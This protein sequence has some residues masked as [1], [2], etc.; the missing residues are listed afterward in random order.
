MD[1]QQLLAQY[2]KTGSQ[3]AFAE[4]VSRHLNFVY[5]TA[6]RQVRT[7]QL[8]EDVTQIVFANLA[9]KAAAMPDQIVLA[10]WLHRDARFTAL[11]VLRA[12][13]RR[14]AREQEAVLMNAPTPTPDPDWEQARP[15]LDEA[16]NAMLPLDRD[17]LL[18]RF[19]EKRS[20]KQVGAALGWSEEAARK[21]VDRALDKLRALLLRRGVTASAS[22]LSLAIMAN[23]IQSAPASLAGTI[24]AASLAAGAITSVNLSTTITMSQI[25]TAALVVI[26]AA[27]LTGALFQYHETTKLRAANRDL[28]RQIQQ[29]AALQAENES[30]SN[31]T[32]QANA[33]GLTKAQLSELLRL[34]GEVGRLRAQVRPGQ[35]HPN[36]P[37]AAPTEPPDDASHPY[38]AQV[39]AHVGNGKTVVTGGW[40]TAP[41]KRTFLVMTPTA[42][43]LT[44]T[45]D[46][47]PGLDPSQTPKATV[48]LET[49]TAEIP[50]T[51]LAQLGL[52]SVKAEGRESTAQATLNPNDAKTLLTKLAT[53]T[54]GIM[55][56]GA[57]ITVFDGFSGMIASGKSTSEPA[58][59]SPFS[60]SV[61]P[62]VSAD[63]E[64][65]DL[66]ISASVSPASG[67]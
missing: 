63:L 6:L 40:A 13:S 1:D 39:T 12:E 20:F 24:T 19:F 35:P 50:E 42:T 4:L 41:G 55:C 51:M 25:K 49:T 60:I 23:G 18:L 62:Q 21:R 54:E 29:L 67:N 32:A 26:A 5:S 57:R 22:A 36:P 45:A 33:P 8:A 58:Q 14:Q 7:R 11:D 52:D 10:G 38:L 30:L 61:T 34:R 47:P 28:R 48:T 46:L 27:G 44:D 65:L 59:A 43:P 64:S 37:V 9:R 2:A 31:R 3:E 66:S 53:P 15:W 16:L 56:A 17:A